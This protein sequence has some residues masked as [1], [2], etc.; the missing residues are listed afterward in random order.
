MVGT[1][2][3][4]YQTLAGL[5]NDLV[6][7]GGGGGP[8]PPKAPTVGGKAATNDPNYQVSIESVSLIHS[9]VFSDTRGSSQ[10]RNL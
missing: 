2:D 7:G 3:P 8:A 4:N 1:A 10:R 6:F 5:N 9:W